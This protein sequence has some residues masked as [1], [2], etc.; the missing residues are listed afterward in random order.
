MAPAI[1]AVLV[2]GWQLFLADT[3]VDP[4]LAVTI[5]VGGVVLLS[6][7]LLVAA[8]LYLYL[9]LSGAVMSREERRRGATS[10]GGQLPG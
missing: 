3:P 10:S 2:L 1:I 6:L 7:W 5:G 4:T 8:V 9:A